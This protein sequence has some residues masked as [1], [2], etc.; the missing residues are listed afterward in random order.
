MKLAFVYSLLL[1]SCLIFIVSV[2]VSCSL[3]IVEIISKLNDQGNTTELAE[4]V[5]R[6]LDNIE[7]FILKSWRRTK[8]QRKIIKTFMVMIVHKCFT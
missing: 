4:K 1:K 2:R 6:R 5:Y 7:D 8:Y 3:D